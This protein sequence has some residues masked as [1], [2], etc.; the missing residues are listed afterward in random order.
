MPCTAAT[1]LF[2]SL[3]P[4][5]SPSWVH[6]STMVVGSSSG[7]GGWDAL[8]SEFVLG[9]EAF[10]DFDAFGSIGRGRV[11]QPRY[12]FVV[13]KSR[14]F[15]GTPRYEVSAVRFMCAIED[16][17]DF[18]YEDGD[19][20]AHAAAVQ[21]GYG[22]GGSSR[23]VHGKIYRH[24]IEISTTYSMPFDYECIPGVPPLQAMPLGQGI[25]EGDQ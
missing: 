11:I 21:I 24:R 19:L 17:Y 22:N 20:P 23:N 4:Q 18:N 15:F 2:A 13:T 9:N 14:T 7:Y 16:L 12:Q 1:N 8:F 10:S 25:Q 6:P 3:S 5:T